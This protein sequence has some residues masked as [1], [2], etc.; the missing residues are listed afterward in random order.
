M[1]IFN[2]CYY[3]VVQLLNYSDGVYKTTLRIPYPYCRADAEW[4]INF[5]KTIELERGY[6]YNFAIRESN[7]GVDQLLGGVGIVCIENG[8]AE[9]GYWIGEPFWGYGIMSHCLRSFLSA[10]GN[11]VLASVFI[12]W[13]I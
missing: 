10:V 11:D 12:P 13:F 6:P 3:F 1:Y 5:N 4:W 2:P 9:I 8:V 7:N